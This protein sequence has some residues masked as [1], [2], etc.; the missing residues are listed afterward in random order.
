MITTF[1]GGGGSSIGYRLAGGQVLMANDFVPQ[2]ART[3]SNNFPDV[4][5]DQRD[6]RAISASNESVA[7]FLG[8]V[9]LV[10]GE[11]DI[12]DGSPPCCEF[13]TAGRGIGDQDVLRPYS[14]VRQNNIAS[15]PFDFADLVRKAKPKVF[16]CENVPAFASGRGTEVF[17]RFLRALRSPEGGSGQ[18]Y[19]AAPSVLSA[20][21]YGVP[22]K[23]LR[24]FHRWRPQGRR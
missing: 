8:Q 12:L 7:A 17:R 20:S 9:G 15:L 14:D 4:V 11:L 5:V 18:A 2:A 10:A 23:R 6:I 19:Y 3:Y 22:Q 21:D 13:S 24:L 1:A 16:I